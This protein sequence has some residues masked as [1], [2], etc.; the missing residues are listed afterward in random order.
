MPLW[1]LVMYTTSQMKPYEGSEAQGDCRRS[2]IVFVH[3]KGGP[4]E[5]S[6]GNSVGPPCEH[7]LKLTREEE[8]GK[9]GNAADFL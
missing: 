2:R 6:T 4:A 7:G 1:V 8:G 9:Q 3:I 5:L